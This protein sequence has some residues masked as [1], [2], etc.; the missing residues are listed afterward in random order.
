MKIAIIWE[1][2][3]SGGVDTHLLNL[4]NNWPKGDKF[5]IFIIE[6][7]RGLVELIRILIF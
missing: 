6:V 4:L 5:I 1:Q 2:I 7:T 3:L